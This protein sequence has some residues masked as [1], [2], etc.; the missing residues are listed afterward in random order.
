MK[1]LLALISLT[2]AIKVN[3]QDKEKQ[4]VDDYMKRFYQ[5]LDTVQWLCAYDDIAWRT[6]DSVYATPKEEQQKLGGQWFCFQVGNIWHAAYGKYENNS[7]TTVYHYWVD[8][9]NIIK[10]VNSQIDSSLS[11]SFSRAL[12]NSRNQL[13]LYNDSIRVQFNQYIKKNN[14]NTISVWLLPAF[15]TKGI[16]VYGGE[17][18][19]LYDNTGNNLLHKS[20]FAKKYRGFKPDSKKEIWIEY[21]T[22][23]EPT[24]GAIFFVWYYRKYFDRIVADAKKFKSTVFHDE[25]RYYWVHA[26][27]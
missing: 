8:T 2:F 14:D 19:Y 22:V 12:I 7:F 3:A 10:R 23:D 21:E 27:K 17:F 20:E 18:Y 9:N 1:Y 13:D 11:N 4:I 25:K 5:K 6:S 16:A 24:L 15:S 26:V